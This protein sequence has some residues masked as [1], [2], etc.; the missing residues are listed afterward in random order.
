VPGER[1]GAKLFRVRLGPY[2]RIEDLNRA[3]QR[4]I[5]NGVEATLVAPGK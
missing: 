1:D 2:S 5:E 4:L 3:R